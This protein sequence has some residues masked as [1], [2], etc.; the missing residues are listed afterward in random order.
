MKYKYRCKACGCP[1]DP[2]EGRLCGECLEQQR[3]D[4]EQRKHCFITAEGQQELRKLLGS[5]V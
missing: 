4:E 1:L 2:G 5:V 3:K